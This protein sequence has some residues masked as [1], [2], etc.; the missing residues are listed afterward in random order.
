MSLMEAHRYIMLQKINRK[1]T[2]NDDN[3]YPE[4]VVGEKVKWKI[5][6]PKKTWQNINCC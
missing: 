1:D 3:G 6:D 5:K 2:P 4:E